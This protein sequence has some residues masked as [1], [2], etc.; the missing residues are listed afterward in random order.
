MVV[1]SLKRVLVPAF[2]LNLKLAA[3]WQL[4]FKEDIVAEV[5]KEVRITVRMPQTLKDKIAVDANKLGMNQAEFIRYVLVTYFA[6]KE[7]N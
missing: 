2:F 7:K 6:E 3:I 5:K 4:I 1:T